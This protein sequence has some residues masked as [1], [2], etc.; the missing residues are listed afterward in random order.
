MDEE[1][2]LLEIG[3]TYLFATRYNAEDDTHTLN[4]HSNASKL[5]SSDPGFDKKDL[6]A[7]VDKDSKIK[8]LEVA[9]ANEILLDADIGHNNT[10]N[11]F[12]SLPPDAK[13]AAVARADAARVELEAHTQE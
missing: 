1:S 8:S 2:K 5:L 10:R 11:S 9:Y 4:S 3:S 13:A 7:L 6:K 12:Q